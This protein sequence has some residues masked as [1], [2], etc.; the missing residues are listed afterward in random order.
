MCIE[1]MCKLASLLTSSKRRK[2]TDK[3]SLVMV[4]ETGVAQLETFLWISLIWRSTLCGG[5][6]QEKKESRRLG[7][8]WTTLQI[9]ISFVSGLLLG[10]LLKTIILLTS[11]G[12][13]ALVANA[14]WRKGKGCI[15]VPAYKGSSA[16]AK[17]VPVTE[18]VHRCPNSGEQEQ[19]LQLSHSTSDKLI[20][21]GLIMR[22]CVHSDHSFHTG[23][24]DQQQQ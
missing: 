7:A 12:L 16:E 15:G 13:T 9:P 17:K 2:E 8:W 23:Q 3:D 14:S 11:R 22:S 5:G 1:L 6:E 10:V 4:D 19:Y 21:A 24:Q 20:R 18:P